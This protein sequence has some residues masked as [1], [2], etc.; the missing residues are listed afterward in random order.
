MLD[1]GGSVNTGSAFL[2]SMIDHMSDPKARFTRASHASHDHAQ[3]LKACP[4]AGKEIRRLSF[5]NHC[6]SQSRRQPKGDDEKIRKS[7]D[8]KSSAKKNIVM[9]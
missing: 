1:C 5:M 6:E 4:I 2:L 7:H 9:S 8:I 3:D